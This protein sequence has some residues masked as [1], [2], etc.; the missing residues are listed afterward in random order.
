MEFNYKGIKGKFVDFQVVETGFWFTWIKLLYEVYND[1]GEVIDRD[2]SLREY[3][4]YGF[5][6]EFDDDQYDE[7]GEVTLSN[8][9]IVMYVDELFH[10][11]YEIEDL[12]NGVRRSSFEG[13]GWDPVNN[14]DDILKDMFEVYFL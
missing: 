1:K 6:P 3:G 9:E 11:G 13:K 8:D 2:W 10:D 7:N 4:T 14:V 12:I 5:E